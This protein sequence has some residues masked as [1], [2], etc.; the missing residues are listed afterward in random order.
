M[1]WCLEPPD[2]TIFAVEICT[3]WHCCVGGKTR[4]R[5][6]EVR[7]QTA[8]SAKHSCWCRIWHH[9]SHKN[10]RWLTMVALGLGVCTG[11]VFGKLRQGGSVVWSGHDSTRYVRLGLFALVRSSWYVP[12][13]TF[14]LVCFLSVCSFL[15]TRRATGHSDG[16]DC[17]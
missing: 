10:Y 16:L 13:G 5:T 7:W 15:Q 14:L 9:P 1:P 4:R 6:G 3:L 17:G 12:R 2:S 8:Q 11:A